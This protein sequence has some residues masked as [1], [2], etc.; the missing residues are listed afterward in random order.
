[1]HAVMAIWCLPWEGGGE[2]GEEPKRGR[3]EVKEVKCGVG[4]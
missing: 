3:V 2:G 4:G 1:M